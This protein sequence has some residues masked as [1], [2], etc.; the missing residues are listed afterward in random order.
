MCS[1]SVKAVTYHSYD[2]IR[3]ENR[4]IPTITGNELLV[5]VH[6]CGLCG[7]DILKIIQQVP[8]P[9]SLGHELTGTIV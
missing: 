5:K 9:V 8:P 1:T 2:N 4:Y 3:I 7:S 6:G